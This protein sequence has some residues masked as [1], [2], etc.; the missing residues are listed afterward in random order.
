MHGAAPPPST[1]LSAL[2]RVVGGLR[3]GDNV[4]W[5]VDFPL[6]DGRSLRFHAD[7]VK[8]RALGWLDPASARAAPPATA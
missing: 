4:V 3:P 2:D 8:Q 5:Q 1:G 6:P 7:C